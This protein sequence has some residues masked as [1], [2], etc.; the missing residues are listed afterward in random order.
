M[1]E[2]EKEG[3]SVTIAVENGLEELGLRRDQVEVQVLEEAAAG[4]LGI[5][6]KPARV[7]IREK[8]WEEENT[9]PEKSEPKSKS[10][11][12]TPAP[13]AR[14]TPRSKPQ[15]RPQPKREAPDREITQGSA[16]STHRQKAAAAKVDSSKAC[17][18]AESV[19]GEILSLA[20]VADA[21]ITAVW[22]AEQERVRA[23]VET[24]DGGLIIGKGGRTI[25]ALQFLVTVI[26]GR[27]VGAPTAVQVDSQGY[28]KKLESKI[29]SEAESAVKEVQRTGSPFRFEPMD[30]AMRRLIHRRLADH[31]DIVTASEGEGSWRKVVLK[32]RSKA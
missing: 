10:A 5:G 22:D 3:K 29:I 15:P 7:H 25:E 19:I 1:K 17:S 30:A 4:F 21:K 6:S 2:I 23:E 11:A 9:A 20:G 31:P 16:A 26:V 28:W 14:R 32:P 13:S 24:D 8:R 27:R 12:H 18:E